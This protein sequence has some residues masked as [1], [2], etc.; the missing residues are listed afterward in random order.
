[1][2]MS[3][4]IPSYDRSLHRRPNPKAPRK[5]R[6]KRLTYRHGNLREALIVE[7]VKL[8]E[9]REDSAFALREVAQR[10]RVSHTAAYRHFP[11]KG[12]LLAEMAKRGFGILAEALEASLAAGKTSDEVVRGQAR[13]YIKVALKNRALF[14]CMFGPRKF[15]P[16]NNDA[17][18][19]S[20]DVCFDLLNRAAMRLSEEHQISAPAS[21]TSLAI[22][23]MVHG[24]TNL[25]LDGQLCDLGDEET[26]EGYEQ[27][28]DKSARQLMSGLIPRVRRR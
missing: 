17:V 10:I 19:K 12:A 1:M 23:S 22:W 21:E 8:M 20:C 13:A 26:Q 24:L 3:G 18:D 15:G 7:A 16:E 9:E 28:A 14:R 25:A 5:G 4:D 27:M 11:N 6:A 2:A